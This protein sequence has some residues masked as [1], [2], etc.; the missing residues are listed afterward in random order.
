MVSGLCLQKKKALR[1]TLMAEFAAQQ[2]HEMGHSESQKLH[3]L[4]ALSQAEACYPPL[5]KSCHHLCNSGK[6]GHILALQML[7]FTVQCTTSLPS[8]PM[9]ATPVKAATKE[10][11]LQGRVLP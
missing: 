4:K 3:L 8:A 9:K 11:R 5:A 6:T 10:A 7:S 2:S 1:V